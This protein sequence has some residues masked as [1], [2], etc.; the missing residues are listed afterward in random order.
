VSRT[1]VWVGDRFD[2]VIELRRAPDVEVFMDD[3]VPDK[4]RLDGLEVL[5]TAADRDASDA[6]VVVDRVRFTLTT[7]NVEAPALSVAAIPVRFSVRR[8]GQ[9]AEE[10]LPAGEV[11]VPALHMDL[12]STITATGGAVEIRDRRPVRPLPRRVRF[13]ERAGWALLA[14]A[15]VPVLSWAVRLV[16]RVRRA[17]PRR[18]ARVPLR[19]RRAALEEIRDADVSTPAAR[20]N[21]YA[22]LDAWI[23]DNVQLAGGVPAA[24]LTPEELARGLGDSKAAAWRDEL[25]RVLLECERAK[26]SRDLPPDDRWAAAVDAAVTLTLARSQP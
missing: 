20:R 2:Y 8:A 18:P 13:A 3:L 16:R 7:F 25:E 14:L 22:A 15:V 17:R 6:K 9:K 23:R 10:A 1:A 11:V 5:V 4:L 26:Y 21:A 12:R 19:Q 24:A